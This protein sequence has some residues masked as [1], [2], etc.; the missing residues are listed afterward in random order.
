MDSRGITQKERYTKLL[1]GE[2]DP[3]ITKRTVGLSVLSIPLTLGSI[4]TR[5]P[6]EERELFGLINLLVNARKRCGDGKLFRLEVELNEGNGALISLQNDRTTTLLE[7]NPEF[8]KDVFYLLAFVHELKKLYDKYYVSH[9]DSNIN[10][11]VSILDRLSDFVSHNMI[12][13]FSLSSADRDM[14][15]KLM[16]YINVFRILICCKDDAFLRFFDD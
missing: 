14:T 4:V 6:R 13:A 16:L 7:S 5:D 8:K 2:K 10:D 11:I 1:K 12:N 15:R 3:G 9:D